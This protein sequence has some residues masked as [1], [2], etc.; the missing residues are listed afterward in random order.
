MRRHQVLILGGGIAALSCAAALSERGI[1][2]IGVYADSYGG[3]PYVAAINFVLPGNP[4]GDSVGL[5][6]EDMLEA[7]YR[8]ADSALVQALCDASPLGYELLARWGVRF[9]LESGFPLLRRTSGS[10]LPRSLCSTQGLIGVEILKKLTEGLAQRNVTLSYG[11]RALRLIAEGG[12]VVGAT[13]RDERGALFNVFAP[14]VVAA[15]GG[16]GNLLEG[17]TYPSDVDGL[18]MAEAFK[19]GAAMIDMEFLEFE[20]MIAVH[21]PD[22]VGEPCPTAMLG[23]GA[24]LLDAGM[25]RFL[26]DH[27]PE[28][29]AG[30]PKTLLNR[31][32][33]KV[34]AEGRGG[35]HGGVYVDLRDIPLK[36]LKAYPW[37]YNR[38]KNAGCDPAKELVEVVPQ[39]HSFS[40]GIRVDAF[41]RATAPGLYAIGEAAGGFHGAC[42]IGGN[43]ASQAVLSAL[44]CAGAIAAGDHEARDFRDTA[45]EWAENA[46][47]AAAWSPRLKHL[48][49]R[50]LGAYRDGGTMTDAARAL[51]EMIRS[52]RLRADAATENRASVLLI[53]ILAALHREESRGVHLRSDFPEKSKALER[54]FS[55]RAEGK[56]SALRM[57]ID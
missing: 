54:E 15:W 24:R 16:V 6:A 14:H 30:A 23:E 42:R 38:M 41:C 43:A 13:L 44:L 22:A 47:T 11:V 57:R 40:G 50:A 35:A 32:I 52:A 12:R 20:P 26:L 34:L 7:G 29:E 3:S 18:M 51:E 56:G 45:P 49:A 19:A 1:T 21:P 48:A 28:G 5:Y 27:R 4:H 33:W 2:D 53:M 8:I 46:E 25:R 10:S 36:T 17:S 37:F 39:A 9:S 31:A 55:I